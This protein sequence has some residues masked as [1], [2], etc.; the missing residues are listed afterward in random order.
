MRFVSVFC[1]LSLLVLGLASAALAKDV[2]TTEPNWHWNAFGRSIVP[3][4]EP[5]DTCPGQA[6]NCGD[7]V[8]PACLCTNGDYDWYY[9]NA[10]AGESLTIATFDA[11]DCSYGSGV[12]DTYIYL[13]ANDCS[14]VL[15]QDDDSGPGFYSLI[16]A[17]TAPYTGQYEVAVRAYSSSELG[18]YTLNINCGTLLTGACCLPGGVCQ[19]L[20]Q[21]D[22]G[23]SGGTYQGDNTS[24]SPNPCPQPPANDVCSGAIVL[25]RCTAGSLADNTVNYTN[26]YDPGSG[27]CSSGYPEAGNDAVYVCD[28]NAGDIIDMTYTQLNLDGAF[29]VVTDC[30]NIAGSCVVGADDTVTGQAE[31]IHYTVPT[32]GTYYIIL[33]SYTTGG[34]PWTMD[35]TFTCPA[36]QA[37]CFADGHCEMQ[38]AADCRA[39]GGQP[40]GNG[41]TCDPN[42]CHVVATQPSTW[43]HIK[44][45]YR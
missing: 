7:T 1:I 41:T 2:K 22:C 44:G 43:G 32:T 36:P 37:C 42:P 6:I 29:Y 28:W 35:Y 13:Y 9:F 3:E 30:S 18:C 39:M 33:D 20:N 19:I 16:N 12:G 26:N 5:N 25:E 40:Q 45:S 11:A 14:T 34:G 4:Q 27:G 8:D 38:Y 31:T 10:N 17:F 24:C 15:A 23:N 21:I